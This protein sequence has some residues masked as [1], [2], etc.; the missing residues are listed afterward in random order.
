VKCGLASLSWNWFL[1][2]YVALIAVLLF[3]TPAHSEARHVIQDL[4]R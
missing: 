1:A 3:A 4:V 2:A